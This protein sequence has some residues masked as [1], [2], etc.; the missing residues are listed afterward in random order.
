MAT[1]STGTDPRVVQD[2]DPELLWA[3]HGKKITTVALIV[4]GLGLA[5]YVW[6]RNAEQRSEQA[7]SRLATARDITG[8]EQIVQDYPR[9]EVAAQALVRLA[10]A[11]YASGKYPESAQKYQQLLEQFPSHPLVPSALVG[12]AA[13]KEA[14][15]NYQGALDQ[16]QQILTSNPRGYVTLNAAMGVARCL[17]ALGKLPEARQKYEEVMAMAQGTRAQMEAYVRWTTLGRNLPTAPNPTTPAAGP[18]G[19]LPALP[20]EK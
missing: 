18:S 1:E 20:V 4:A 11:Y 2:F 8:L 14:Q 6:Q 5:A 15:A 7:A 10:D 9:Q 19:S 17:E 16:Y 3:Q 12:Q 13:I